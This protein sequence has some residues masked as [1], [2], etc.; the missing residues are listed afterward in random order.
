MGWLI[1]SLLSILTLVVQHFLSTREKA[2]WGAVLPVCFVALMMYLRFG[3]GVVGEKDF[4]FILT[5]G[6]VI[7]LSIWT[8]GRET[9]KKSRKRELDKMKSHDLK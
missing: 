5:L 6:T 8:S 7:L 4:W 2:F 3:G 1:N 9:L